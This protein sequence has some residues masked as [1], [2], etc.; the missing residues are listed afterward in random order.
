MKRQKQTLF[1]E[2][3]ISKQTVAAYPLQDEGM[4]T[5][6]VVNRMNNDSV[7]YFDLVTKNFASEPV[8][9]AES[10]KAGKRISNGAN[11]NRKARFTTSQDFLPPPPVFPAAIDDPKDLFFIMLY[12]FDKIIY[13]DEI[14]ENI[15]KFDVS[16]KAGDID[17]LN[18]IAYNCAEIIAHYGIFT[19]LVPLRRLER[20]KHVTELLNA[21]T[22]SGQ[23]RKEF[24]RFRFNLKENLEQIRRMIN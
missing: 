12:Y 14:S 4:L 3:N 9:S 1:P 7:K 13:L 5:I 10:R 23:V 18:S 2:D 19:A 16:I 8:N 6:T 20:V 24:E 11:R 21:I 22:L 15:E 17:E